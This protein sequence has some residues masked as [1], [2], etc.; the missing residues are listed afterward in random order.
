MERIVTSG[1][2][3]NLDYCLEDVLDEDSIEEL[4]DF[5]NE[6]AQEGSLAELNEEFGEDYEEEELRLVRLKFFSEVAN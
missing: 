4:F 5:L 3:I 6:E 1:T 2:R